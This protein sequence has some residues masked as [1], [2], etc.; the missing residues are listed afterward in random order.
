MLRRQLTFQCVLENATEPIY[1]GIN[2]RNRIVIDPQ[3]TLHCNPDPQR[4]H[5]I[6]LGDAFDHL[7]R[8]RGNDHARWSLV[9]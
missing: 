4:L 3:S 7:G 8:G 5:S 9:K 1:G 6:F 2:A